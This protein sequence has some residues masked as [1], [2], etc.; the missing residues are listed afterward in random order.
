MASKTI[1]TQIPTWAPVS[2]DQILFTDTSDWDKLKKFDYWNIIDEAKLS[3][4]S[5]VST[6]STISPDN[7]SMIVQNSSGITTTLPLTPS[8]WDNFSVV[9]NSGGTN[10]IDGNWNNISWLATSPIYDW[11]SFSLIYTGTE[12]LVF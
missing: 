2:A 4:V 7:W 10:T 12:R 9:N 3:S 5:I 8:Q 11:E 1:P 6:S